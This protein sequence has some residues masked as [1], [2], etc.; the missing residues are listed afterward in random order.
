MAKKSTKKAAKRSTKK[1]AAKRSAKPKPRAGARK[2]GGGRIVA[3]MIEHCRRLPGATED[4]KWGD[5]L[6]F[7][8]GG[9]MFAGF[10]TDGT[11]QFAFRC[12]DE[13]FDR[14]VEVDGIIPAPYAA[15]FAW[16]KVLRTDALPERELRALLEQAHA[17]ILSGLPKKKQEAIRTGGAAAR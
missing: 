4:I 16:V 3:K 13:D 10:D 6:I 5:N 1:K 9:K 12:A 15:K 14:L 2:G 8:V 7:S 17:I 11:D